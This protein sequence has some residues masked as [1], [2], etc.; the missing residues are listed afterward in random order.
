MLVARRW[1]AAAAAA[2]DD[3]A[4]DAND[5]NAGVV[6]ANEAVGA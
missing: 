6:A 1:A 2:A 4:N 3:D 5:A